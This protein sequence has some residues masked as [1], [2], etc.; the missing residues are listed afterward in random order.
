MESKGDSS[1]RDGGG[2]SGLTVVN[3]TDG[4]DVNVR[5][6]TFELGLCQLCPPGL[7]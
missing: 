3:V 4:T 2:Q 5:L 7:G 1:F 6:L